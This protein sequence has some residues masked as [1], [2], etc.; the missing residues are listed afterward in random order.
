LGSIQAVLFCDWNA[1][2]S[3]VGFSGELVKDAA[4]KIQVN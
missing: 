2:E 4:G 3:Y 1:F